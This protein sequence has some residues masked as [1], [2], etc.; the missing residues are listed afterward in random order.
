MKRKSASSFKHP[1]M[2]LASFQLN[3]RSLSTADKE[4]ENFLS[5]IFYSECSNGNNTEP[6][7]A[8]PVKSHCA[9]ETR[10][11]KDI[12]TRLLFPYDHRVPEVQRMLQSSKPVK[13]DLNQQA[14]VSDH[15]FSEQTKTRLYQ[16]CNRTMALAVGRGMA[17][18]QYV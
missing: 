4:H 15:D 14:G 5:G 18:L 8:K 9:A 6:A 17:C 1:E 10:P 13:I 12:V 3:L 16:L 11:V 7:R 2:G